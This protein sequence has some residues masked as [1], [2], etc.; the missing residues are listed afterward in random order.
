MSKE[1]DGRKPWTRPEIKRLGT[2][3]EVAGNQTP[4]AQAVGAKS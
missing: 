1:N 4:K 3:K 2:I